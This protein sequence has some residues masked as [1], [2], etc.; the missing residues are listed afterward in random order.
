MRAP[1]DVAQF[2]DDTKPPIGLIQWEKILCAFQYI[3][4]PKQM[5]VVMSVLFQFSYFSSR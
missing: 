1:I 3:C 4:S 5:E 2:A